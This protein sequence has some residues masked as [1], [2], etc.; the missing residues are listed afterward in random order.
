MERK[1]DNMIA[2]LLE[3]R[4][5]RVDARFEELKDESRASES[6]AVRLG[7]P[8]RDCLDPQDQAALCLE[9]RETG[10]YVSVDT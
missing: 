5:E 7:S 2:A 4:R 6:C 10:R 1:L 9:D 8:G 3:E